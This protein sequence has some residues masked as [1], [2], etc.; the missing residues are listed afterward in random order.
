MTDTVPTLSGGDRTDADF[1]A[2]APE[3]RRLI[4]SVAEVAQNDAAHSSPAP[5]RA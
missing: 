1:L 4:L 2:R 3:L 5:D